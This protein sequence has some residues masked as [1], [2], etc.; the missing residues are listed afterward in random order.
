MAIINGMYIHVVD[1]SA[2]WEVTATSHPVESGLPLT[3]TV[4]AR[5]LS[6]SL[7]GKIVDYGNVKAS[8]VIT[9]LKQWQSSG[10]LIEYQGNEI[11]SGMQIRS[12]ETDRPNTVYG[13]ADFSMELVQVRIAKS[14]YVPKKTN[15]STSTGGTT[16]QK[17]EAKKPENLNIKVGDVVVFKGGPVYSS[18]DAKKAAANRNRS[19]CKVTKISTA[20]YSV[21]QYHL[22]SNDGGKVYGWVDKK[23]IEGKASTSTSGKTNAGTQ[24]TKSSSKSSSKK[25]VYHK[26]KKGDTVWALVR[27]YKTGKSESWVISNNPKAFSRKGDART[28][29]IG[30]KL[31]M[32]YK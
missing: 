12:L 32:G 26:V 2:S 15:T 10:S 25:A 5:A 16:A 18:S 17:T 9:K 28:L 30:K 27:K 13:G 7:S 14:A 31:L 1:E 11:A 23:N 24:Q 21:H 22:I 3:D 6:L 20:S 29:Q 4:V 19:T 8:E